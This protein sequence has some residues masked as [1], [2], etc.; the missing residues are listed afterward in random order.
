[1]KHFAIH[2]LDWID[3]RILNHRFPWLCN[4]VWDRQ[5]EIYPNPFDELAKEAME[6][7]SAGLTE[8]FDLGEYI[9]NE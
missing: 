9:D 7:H 8:D 4:W 3:N 5:L 1:M 6:E 2:L